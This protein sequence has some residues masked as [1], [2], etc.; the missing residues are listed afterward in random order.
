MTKKAS[1]LIAAAMAVSLADQALAL[2]TDQCRL[3]A[4]TAT[5][6]YDLSIRNG[7]SA[8]DAEA[9]AQS[10]FLRRLQEDSGTKISSMTD[11]LDAC[12]T[13][14]ISHRAMCARVAT[15]YTGKPC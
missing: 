1:L 11:A 9:S 12:K 4:E 13:A 10:T 15:F 2:T 14:G 8:A 6:V 3:A 5:G 7:N